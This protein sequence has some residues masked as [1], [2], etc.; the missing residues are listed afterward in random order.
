MSSAGASPDYQVRF[1]R[2][3][4]TA[5]LVPLINVAF[6]PEQ[7][8][9]EGDRINAEKLHLFFENG[10]FLVIES[11]E[12]L[13]G[14]VYAEVRG[15]RGYIGLLALRPELKGRGLGRVLMSHAEEY[16]GGAGC[17]AADLRTISARTD[18]VPMY[19]HLGYREMGTA[20]MP[21]EIPLR[22]PC[23]FIIMSK[24]LR[25]PEQSAP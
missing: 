9:I 24:Q 15:S 10:R 7:I 21:P 17:E 18:L 25:K 1:G 14:C 11:A 20:A 8:A 13:A 4:D 3:D 22:I 23:H 16:L 12:G 5:Q 19:R 6:L 2:P